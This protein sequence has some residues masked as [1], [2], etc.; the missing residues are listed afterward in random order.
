M[1]NDYFARA[2]SRGAASP[3]CHTSPARE[4]ALR[5]EAGK[6]ADVLSD[7]TGVSP[8]VTGSFPRVRQGAVIE[9]FPNAFL[10]VCL[11]DEVYATTLTLGRGK[12]FG[13][14]YGKWREQN[15]ITRLPGLTLTERR[16]FQ[17]R[18]DKT[19]HHEH[20][21]ALICV[22]TALL[23]ARNHFTAVGDVEGG[24]F[25]LPP[26]PSGKSGH[27]RP[28][29][30]TFVNSIRRVQKFDWWEMAMSSR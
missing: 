30:V 6:A 25:F 23:T 9:A 13:W 24:W 26:C 10:G 27:K 1:S 8:R 2:R 5:E 21:A 20:Q 7:S 22:L 4:F 17:D 3:A 11:T 15:L 29:A 16:L 14:L 12:K 19:T 28:F 18:F